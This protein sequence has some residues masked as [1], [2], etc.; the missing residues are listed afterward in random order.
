VDTLKLIKTCGPIAFLFLFFLSCNLVFIQDEDS[1]GQQK[2]TNV[3][4]LK[5][6]NTD[7][8]NWKMAPSA[9][10][11][12]LWTAANFYDDVDGGIEVYTDKGLIEVADIH[13]VGPTGSDGVQNE[14]A[15]HSFIMDFGTESN[16]QDEFN[17]QKTKYS[18]DAFDI[19]KYSSKIA[20]ARAVFGGITVYAYFRKFYFE[21]QFIGFDNQNHAVSTALLF[22]GLFQMKIG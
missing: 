17:Y 21:L 13:L 16:A 9:D 6:T 15:V 12:T 22:L 19:P 10:S 14:I 11:F 4:M 3:R 1:G 5:F 8:S 2:A 18:A 7:I 20:F